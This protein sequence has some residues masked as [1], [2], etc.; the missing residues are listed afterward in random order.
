[1]RLVDRLKLRCSTATKLS[2][3]PT[4][5]IVRFGNG[6]PA[7]GMVAPETER[8]RLEKVSIRKEVAA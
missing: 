1:M 5:R 8:A 3:L 4:D 6:L 2:E 7:H